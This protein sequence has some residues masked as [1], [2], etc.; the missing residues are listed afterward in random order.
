MLYLLVEEIDRIPKD[1]M[2]ERVNSAE[3]GLDRKRE[4]TDL[5]R[6]PTR[7]RQIPNG[8]FQKGN[9]GDEERR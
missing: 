2:R 8:L 1:A 7:L 4:S 6:L 9:E 5:Y 3:K